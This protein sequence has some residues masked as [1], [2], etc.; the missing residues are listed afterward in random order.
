MFFIIIIALQHP[1]VVDP[2]V[3]RSD[4]IFLRMCL[5]HHIANKSFN[6]TNSE[7]VAAYNSALADIENN[8][9]F[10]DPSWI[11]DLDRAYDGRESISAQIHSSGREVEGDD[12]GGGGGG[13]SGDEG[14]V[15]GGGGGGDVPTFHVTHDQHIKRSNPPDQINLLNTPPP[16]PH[17]AAVV[18][19]STTAAAP[20]PAQEPEE[21]EK[22]NKNTKKLPHPPT[23]GTTR[24]LRSA[25]G[26]LQPPPPCSTTTT[27]SP[28]PAPASPKSVMSSGAFDKFMKFQDS[29][30]QEQRRKFQ[31]LY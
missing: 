23:S 14:G 30:V 20:P 11:A 2:G 1:V 12:G 16:P 21:K 29:L 17:H 22:S 24:V 5:D 9:P 18:P 13:S 6:T 28:P 27:A 8:F 3:T 7:C 10:P 31:R 19:L 15:R 26:A 25:A 4:Y